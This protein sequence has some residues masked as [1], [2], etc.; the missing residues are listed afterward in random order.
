MRY[1]LPLLLLAGCGTP[2]KPEPTQTVYITR[3]VKDCSWLPHMTA[4][5]SDTPETKREIIGYEI[6]RRKNCPKETQ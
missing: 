3:T 1:L 6:A 4:S 5:V 2:A